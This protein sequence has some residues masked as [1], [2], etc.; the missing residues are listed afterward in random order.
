[1]RVV[2]NNNKKANSSNR[3]TRPPPI[4]FE[5][6]EARKLGKDECLMYKLR[7]DPENEES[8]KYD[9][10]IPF[11]KSGTCEQY[12]NFARDLSKVII[13]TNSVTGASK[14]LVTRRMLQGDALAK[15]EAAAATHGDETPENYI[16]C[17]RDLTTHVFPARAL[18]QQRRYMN[19]M[20]R[21]PRDVTI[22]AYMVRLVELNQYLV[23]FPPFQANQH[24]LE[25]QLLDIAEYGVPNSWQTKMREFG[26]DPVEHTMTEFIEMCERFE[27]N[28]D[29]PKEDSKEKKEE[30]TKSFAKRKSSEAE[31]WCE[32][33]QSHT[34][35]TSDCYEVRNLRDAKKAKTNG[36]SQ[37]K[38]WNRK[39]DNK[40][41]K[42]HEEMHALVADAVKRAM[43]RSLIGKKRK[44]DEELAA[45]DE[46]LCALSVS[47][48]SEEEKCHP[49]NHQSSD[50][51]S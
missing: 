31:K 49:D 28:E 18:K 46:Q 40:S 23:D 16:L 11:F 39:S 7:T 44:S 13:G 47:E 9:L 51:D 12:L 3:K 36:T 37:N 19:R 48:A 38:T 50:S 1:M 20:M 5:R 35:N 30:T 27:E 17:L 26:F 6:P 2:S 33:H 34:H 14:Y 21:K 24:L 15:F 45:I 32:I 25:E 22:R 4:P 42:K 41:D 8:A 29:P 10:T 43:K